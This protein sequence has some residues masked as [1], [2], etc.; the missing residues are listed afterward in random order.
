M[1][2]FC[3]IATVATTEDMARGFLILAVLATTASAEPSS[4]P[5][6]TSERF[7]IHVT[8][9]ERVTHPAGATAPTNIIFMN[10]C[11][12]G[13]TVSPGTTDNRTDN[14][15]IATQ[16]SSLAAFNQGD[17]AWQTVMTCMRGTFSR[18]NVQITDV[19]PGTSPHLEVMVAGL[20][21]Q[22]KSNPPLSS[23]VGGIADVSCQTIPGN[24]DTF[25]PNAMVFAFANASFYAGAPLDI[26]ATA[27][28]EIAHTWGLDH[29]VDNTDPMTYN[30]FGGMR[31]YKDNQQCGSDC[32]NGQTAFG[33]TCQGSGGSATHVCLATNTQT[34]DEV[35][36][37]HTLF[38]SSGPTPTVSITSPAKNAVV[39]GGFEIDV[40]C[41][42]TDG[43]SNVTAT[44]GGVSAGTKTAAPFKFTAPKQLAN[45]PY[46]ISATC[47]ATG[48]GT[49]TAMVDITQGVPCTTAGD[50][51]ATEI[52]YA[53]SCVPGPD[54]S[55]GLGVTCAMDSDCASGMCASDGTEKHCVLPCDLGGND[56][57]S[58]FGCLAAGANGVCWPGADD[59]SAGC[60][61][62]GSGSAL[63]FCFSFVGFLFFRRRR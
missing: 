36:T 20:A 45:G 13:C 51:K 41:T 50:C 3:N 54:S 57:P 49:A 44:I 37:I 11:A 4:S 25:I 7:P 39:P 9:V 60:N 53:G 16:L 28:Q 27:A 6:E 29:V 34:Q 52:C 15:D 30:T 8:H 24:C 10:R 23:N 31:Q 22:L 61:S 48:G 14:S 17:A 33:V 58:G 32:F 55:N 56:C 18:F 26:C 40:T 35:S 2:C 43:V 12:S 47:T 63:V 19:D 59:G 62:T 1:R 5:G 38:G 46:T 21:S 42:A